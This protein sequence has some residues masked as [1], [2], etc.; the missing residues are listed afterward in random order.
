MAARADAMVATEP[1]TVA[2]ASQAIADSSFWEN[3]GYGLSNL[4]ISRNYGKDSF[5]KLHVKYK[6]ISHAEI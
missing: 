1:A 2:I 4:S 3:R 5:E 6:F